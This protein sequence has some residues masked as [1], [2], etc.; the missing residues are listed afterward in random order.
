MRKYRKTLAMLTMTTLMAA[1]LAGCAENKIGP[2]PTPAA[3]PTQETPK[4]TSTPTPTPTPFVPETVGHYEAEDAA[5][6]GKVHASTGKQDFS[7]LGY[8]EGFEGDEDTCTFKVDIEKDGFYD[9]VFRLSSMGGEKTNFV[10]LDGERIGEIYISDTTPADAVVKRAYLSGGQHEITVTKS[11]GWIRLDYL[12]LVTSKPIDQEIYMIDKVLCNKNA[13]ENTK[14]LFSYLVDIYGKNILSGQVCDDGGLGAEI[15]VVHDTTGKYP[16]VLS[17][18]LMS[19]TSSRPDGG[20]DGKTIEYAKAWDERGGILEFHWHWTTAEKY[21]TKAWY[22]TFYTE[23]TNFNLEKALNGSDPAGYEMLV[24]DMRNMAETLK[25]LAEA[26]IPI[27]FRPLHEASGGW[28]WWGA[29]GA[30]AY[31]KLY[32]MMYEMFTDE[33]K[34]NNLIWL[35]NGQDKDWYPGDEYCDILGID[36]YPGERVYTSQASKYFEVAGWSEK[37]KPVYLSECGC[38]FDPELAVRDGAM[39]GEF[40]VWQG[41]FVKRASFI[42]LSEQY[43]EGYM[44]KKAYDSDTVITLDEIP[45]LKKYPM[46]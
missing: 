45:D 39:W 33:Y 2:T 36:I 16:A 19:Y 12:E 26:D 5:F 1:S 29:S 10:S 43:T 34:L 21:T 6:T 4:Q 41:E 3:S 42:K 23:S 11:W 13:S 17:M 15:R 28:F 18:D 7:N 32:I 31:K 14:R 37:Q 38:I 40:C 24:T 20:K 25:P 8:A 9:L 44:M 35:W 22:S 27:L 46:E 30:E